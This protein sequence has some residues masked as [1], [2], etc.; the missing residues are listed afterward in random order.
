VHYAL[1]LNN[2]LLLLLLLRIPLHDFDVR[3]EIAQILITELGMLAQEAA[4]DHSGIGLESSVVIDYFGM[5]FK[6][7]LVAGFRGDHG[8]ADKFNVAAT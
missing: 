1:T 6:S 2:D 8:G 4:Y 7:L 5:F 3:F